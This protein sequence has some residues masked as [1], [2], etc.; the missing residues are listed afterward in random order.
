VEP[1]ANADDEAGSGGPPFTFEPPHRFTAARQGARFAL[2]SDEDPGVLLVAPHDAPD[3]AALAAQLAQGWI[4]EQVELRPSA[5]PARDADGLLVELAG[6]FRGEP[7]RAVVRAVCLPRGGGVLVVALAAEVHWQ[8]RRYEAYARMIVRSVRWPEPGSA[9]Q[10]PAELAALD[11]WLRGRSLVRMA[12]DAPRAGGVFTA[13]GGRQ[14]LLLHADGRF[15][16]LG[17]LGAPGRRATGRW[18][19]LATA[20]GPALELLDDDGG[21]ARVRVE[22]GEH[23]TFLD[24]ARFYV[25]D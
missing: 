15:E 5:P 16:S 22:T 2:S 14:E 7:A 8:P 9:P 13:W 17:L 4:D 10:L 25:G 24:G 3:E 18:R 6:R 11:G 19:L 12:S 20:D 1:A 21:V 23:G